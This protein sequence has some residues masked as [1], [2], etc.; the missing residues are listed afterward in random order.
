MG[1]ASP[2]AGTGLLPTW[3][4]PSW[5][6]ARQC[7]DGDRPSRE[8]PRGWEQ[9]V[10]SSGSGHGP[11]LDPPR[12]RAKPL[13]LPM[14]SSRTLRGDR[15]VPTSGQHRRPWGKRRA[16]PR[17]QLKE[18]LWGVGG[19]SSP[20]LLSEQPRAQEKRMV[21][22][23]QQCLKAELFQHEEWG[24]SFTAPPLAQV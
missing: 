23:S 14:E 6:P 3:A 11:G 19:V 9:L 7:G 5:D 17:V 2:A 1:C 10:P 18:L 21:V 20:R 13:A 8:K 12:G 4:V 22:T 16:E 15:A 24:L